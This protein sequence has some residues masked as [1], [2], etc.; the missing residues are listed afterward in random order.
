M[1]VRDLLTVQIKQPFRGSEPISQ[2]VLHHLEQPE[3]NDFPCDTVLY[4]FPQSAVRQ[5]FA[6]GGSLRCS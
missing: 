3:P 1:I 4:A 2:L 5:A 6:A